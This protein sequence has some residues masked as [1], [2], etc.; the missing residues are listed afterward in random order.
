MPLARLLCQLVQVS[1][2]I[3]SFVGTMAFMLAG[4]REHLTLR[5]QPEHMC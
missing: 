2:Q 3:E 5:G 1:P 4:E